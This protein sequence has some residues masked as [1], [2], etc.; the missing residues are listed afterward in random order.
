MMCQMTAYHVL[1]NHD[2][3]YISFY[4]Y[5]NAKEVS[6]ALLALLPGILTPALLT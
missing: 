5:Y 2:V 4:V 3:T 6:A 1:M